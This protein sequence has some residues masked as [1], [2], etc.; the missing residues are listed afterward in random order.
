MEGS[1][2][3]DRVQELEVV[4]NHHNKFVALKVLHKCLSVPISGDLLVCPDIADQKG[5]LWRLD[6]LKKEVEDAIIEKQVIFK[7]CTSFSVPAMGNASQSAGMII[8]TIPQLW[9]LIIFVL[10]GGG[11][12][13]FM[14]GSLR[15]M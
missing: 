15:V 6:L 9:C 13:K 12:L 14:I 3:E 2:I 10:L 1:Q 5:P 7:D 11:D 4:A 8:G